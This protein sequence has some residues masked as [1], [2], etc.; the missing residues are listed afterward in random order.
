M[1]D[2]IVIDAISRKSRSQICVIYGREHVLVLPLHSNYC[3]NIS[4]RK[5]EIIHS[6]IYAIFNCGLRA[7]IPNSS[8]SRSV[9]AYL[10]MVNNNK[11]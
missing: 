6:F 1:T 8:T 5:K 9:N 4:K 7:F 10:R 11:I 2:A 3:V